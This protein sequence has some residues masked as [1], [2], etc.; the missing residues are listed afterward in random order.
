MKGGA[1]FAAVKL[2]AEGNELWRWQALRVKESS[3]LE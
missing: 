3:W 1:D 2:D